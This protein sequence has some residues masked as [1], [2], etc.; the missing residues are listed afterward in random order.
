[1]DIF[2]SKYLI[3]NFFQKSY[4]LIKKPKLVELYFNEIIINKYFKSSD[5]KYIISYPKSGRTWLFSI[6]LFYSSQM[7][8]QNKLKNRKKVKFDTGSIEFTH[9]C[10]DPNPYPLKNL[11][12]KNKDLYN[13]KKIIILR[14]P[15]EII[16]SFWYQIKF[17][18]KTTNKNLKELIDDD[19]LGVDKI[20]SFFNL[21]NSELLE[22][23][24][25][26]T[27]EQ[28]I[29]NTFEEL[30]KILIFLNIKVNGKL[31]KLSID[32]CSFEKMQKKEKKESNNIKTE[33]L[34]FRKGSL[35]SYNEDL[36]KSDILNINNKIRNNLNS[37]F[38]SILNLDKI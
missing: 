8:Y 1:M 2:Q 21:L 7:S 3:K 24:K 33:E 18:E 32:E 35:K 29:K 6:L 26:V 10:S 20:I 9:D 14:D 36:E 13:K 38:K 30:R 5:L 22:N 12:V 4:T 11:K 31:L 37:N 34:K 15:R 17:R 28:L 27:Y 19:Y 25:I 23:S 16:V